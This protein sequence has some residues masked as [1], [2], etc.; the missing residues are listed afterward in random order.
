MPS[1]ISSVS[2]GPLTFHLT[3]V[4]EAMPFVLPNTDTLYARFMIWKVET[5]EDPRQW[6][7]PKLGIT[8]Q[9]EAAAKSW[10]T[11]GDRIGNTV[12]LGHAVGVVEVDVLAAEEGMGVAEVLR[13]GCDQLN[14]VLENM[15]VLVGIGAN[16]DVEICHKLRPT[17]YML[18]DLIAKNPKWRKPE[19]PFPTYRK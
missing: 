7:G 17:P 1:S 11:E 6:D 3:V 2:E 8:A 16:V 4:K 12:N 19:Y 10:I 15:A 14:P 5:F 18:S 13:F 9:I